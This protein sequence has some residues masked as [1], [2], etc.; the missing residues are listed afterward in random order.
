METAHHDSSFLKKLHSNGNRHSPDGV[1]VMKG[2]G[3]SARSLARIAG[4]SRRSCTVFATHSCRMKWFEIHLNMIDERDRGIGGEWSDE[5]VFCFLLYAV[6]NLEP[7]PVASRHQPSRF[8]SRM[9]CSH[10]A[11]N[12]Q[13]TNLKLVWRTL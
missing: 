4:G 8:H 11:F 1:E 5:Q 6:V 9:E 3:F 2:Q 13:E 10:P 7:H 12:S